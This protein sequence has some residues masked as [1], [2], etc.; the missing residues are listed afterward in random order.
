MGMKIIKRSGEAVDFD[1][2]KIRQAI[3]GAN[4]DTRANHRIDKVMCDKITEETKDFIFN[5]GRRM[6]VEEIQDYI[7]DSLLLAAPFVAKQFI[8]YREQ[9]T[10]NRASSSI[11]DEVRTILDSTNE[12][13]GKDNSHKDFRK[14]NTKRDM[15]AGIVNKHEA[16]ENIFTH[17][18]IAAH[19]AGIIHIH[20]MDYAAQNMY[21]C[22]LINIEDMLKN[23]TMMGDV[24]IFTPKSFYTAATLLTQIIH[25]V[26]GSQ[27]GLTNTAV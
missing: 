3:L 16:R 14:E 4:K 27:Y 12:E 26:S 11:M 20:D 5:S 10:T 15:V 9:R 23:G 19:D 1:V 25:S 18:M 7:E 8:K 2:E 13:F 17:E 21:N 6:T 22:A 24:K